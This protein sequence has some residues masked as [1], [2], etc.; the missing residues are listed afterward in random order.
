VGRAGEIAALCKLV[1]EHRLVTLVGPGGVGKT[2]LSL[3]V[4]AGV[5]GHH[6]DGVRFVELA[7]LTDERLVAQAIADVLE[8]QE[9]PARPLVQALEKSVGRRRMLIVLDN[10]EHVAAGCAD[11]VQRLLAAAPHLRV[12]ASSREPLHIA[13]EIAFPVPPLALP[14]VSTLPPAQLSRF[15]GVRLFVERARS[16]QPAFELTAS[17]AAYVVHICRRLDGIALAIELAAARVHTL[18]IDQIAARLDDR[19]RLLVSRDRGVLPRQQTLRALIDWS[20][21][22][23]TDADR[24]LLR[25]LAVFA[26]GCT[27][28]AA[29]AVV[30]GDGV[31]PGEVLDGLSRLVE[32]S[33]VQMN[34]TTGR[35]GLLE[36][37]KEYASEQLSNSAELDATRRRHLGY[38]LELAE[39]ARPHFTGAEGKVWLE[40]IDADIDNI[41]AGHA[42]SLELPGAAERGL[43]MMVALKMYYFTRAR[44]TALL[45]GIEVSLVKTGNAAEPA[46]ACRAFHTAGQVSYRMAKFDEAA[47]LFDEALRIARITEDRVRVAMILQELGTTS[48]GQGQIAEARRHV[49]E[50]LQLARTLSD[51]RVLAGALNQMAQLH[52]LCAELDSAEPLYQ[53]AFQILIE[54]ADEE[55]TA[56]LALNLAMVCIAR[57]DRRRAR[58]LLLQAHEIAVSLDSKSTGQCVLAVTSGLAGLVAEWEIVARLEGAARAEASQSGFQLEPADHDFLIPL[59]KRAQDALGPA[60]YARA[61]KHAAEAGYEPAMSSAKAWLTNLASAATEGTAVSP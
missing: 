49:A 28:E 25:R 14:D 5:A 46:I 10:C 21:G 57:G 19:F 8:V 40:R 33:L 32:K 1:G 20:H 38:F 3:Q 58:E 34:P 59:W 2:R 47:D 29:E 9:D 4:A 13:G 52:R 37:V 18:P 24:V 15:E 31:E 44:L 41:Q 26:G 30:G 36:T 39:Q 6:A 61:E 56:A 60:A 54:L 43:R 55:G 16:R 35:Y 45:D 11:V 12:L 48:I 53:Q 22:L 27:L 42:A 51:R 17:N 7:P 50:A 23:L